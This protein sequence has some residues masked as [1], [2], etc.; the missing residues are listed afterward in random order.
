[1]DPDI[2]ELFRMLHQAELFGQPDSEATQHLL[3][4]DVSSGDDQNEVSR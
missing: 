3:G 1:V 4:K 2:R